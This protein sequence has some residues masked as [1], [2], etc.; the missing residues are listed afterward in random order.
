MSATGYTW[1]LT[2]RRSK[3][4]CSAVGSPCMVNVAPLSII[5]TLFAVSVPKS[6]IRPLRLCTGSRRRCACWLPSGV[7]PVTAAPVAPP[8]RAV[9]RQP[10]G[11]GRRTAPRQLAAHV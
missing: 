10:R 4:R 1:A 3:Q 9:A 2:P 7:P 11:R 6:L 5:R 8:A